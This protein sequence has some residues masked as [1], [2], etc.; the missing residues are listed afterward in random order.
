M[1]EQDEVEV[2]GAG[3]EDSDKERKRRVATYMAYAVEGKVG[4]FRRSFKWIEDRY[5]H[6]VYGLR[7]VVNQLHHFLDHFS[8]R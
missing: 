8:C 2:A 5:L 6:L 4:Y 7:M 3:V 1:A